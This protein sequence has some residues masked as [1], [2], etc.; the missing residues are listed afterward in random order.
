MEKEKNINNR[1]VISIGVI[2]LLLGIIL[3]SSN[4]LNSKI[5]K[6]FNNMN[7]LV[8]EYKMNNEVKEIKEEVN[9]EI[10]KPVENNYVNNDTNIS[11]NEN[12]SPSYNYVGKLSIPKINLNQ[13]FVGLDSKYNGVHYGIEMLENSNYPNVS[14]GNLILVSHSGSSY[15][16]HF[17]NLYKLTIGDKCYVDYKGIKYTY[18]I[19]DIYNQ[20]KKG[21]VMI[22]RDSNKTT[23]TLVTCTKNSATEQTIYI[24]ELI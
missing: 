19:K 6:S 5:D 4:Y 13:G 16:S 10:K 18:I 11:K 1:S 21:T 23:L 15:I 7:L 14:N 3:L 17:K 24:A 9:E 20:E 8:L 2:F 12:S 22:K